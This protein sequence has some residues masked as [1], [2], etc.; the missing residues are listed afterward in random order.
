MYLSKLQILGFK[1]F[2]QK[3]KLEFNHGLSCIIGPNGSGK[4]NIVDAIRWVLGEQRTTAL[5]SDK[6]ENVIFN[7]TKLRKPVG[8]AEVALTIQNNRNILN[9]EFNEVVI[10]RR[11]Y[12]S[13]ESEYLINQTP[14]RLKD[15]LDLFMDT[16]MGA[17][18]YSVIE[19]KMVESILSENKAE[20]R[21]LFE[22]AAGVV[23][24]KIR[25]KSALR[26]LEVT[27]IDLTRINDIIGEVDKKVQ[28]L[29]RQVGKTRRY[30][31]YMEE[32]RKT[33]IALSRFRYHR[34]LD[35]LRPLKQQ[36]QEVSR[37]KE[38]SH[39]Q[40]TMDEALLE[41]YKREQIQT[42]QILQTMN[43]Q[44]H[45]LDN[46][47]AQINQEQAVAKTK[48]EEITKTKDRYGI[49]IDDFTKKIGLIR[50]NLTNYEEDLLRLNGQK[51]IFDQKYSEIE[52]ERVAEIDRLQIEKS[53]ID[54]LNKDFRRRF[55]AVSA[56][57]DHLKQKEYQLGFQQDQFNHLEESIAA[58]NT[59]VTR[60]STT[61]QQ[62]QQER[63]QFGNNI[64]E[65]TETLDELVSNKIK[66]S[67]QQRDLEHK[68][69]GLLIELERAHSRQHF[70]ES[71]I[72]NYEGHS[73][74]TQY[75]MSQRD[76]MPGV[77][78]ALADLVSVDENY[79]R[80]IELV[81]GEALNYVIVDNENI[82]G[83]LIQLIK[84][85]KKGRI[86][87][88][89][90]NR[91]NELNPADPSKETE[92]G[93]TLLL[94]QITCPSSYQKLLHVLMGDVAVCDTLDEALTASKNYPRLRFITA[95]GEI[96]NFGREIS[97]GSFEQDS[98][99][100]V[101]RKDQLKKYNDQARHLQS[102][103]NA[104]TEQIEALQSA[105]NK[106][107]GDETSLRQQISQ[108]QLRQDETEKK[109]NQIAFELNKHQ[110]D[111]QA[112]EERL[113]QSRK[114]IHELKQQT[115]T[116]QVA[117]E[118]L[119]KELN[120]LERETIL[121]TNEYEQKSEVM[122]GLLEEVQK[123][124]LNAANLQ[125]QISNRQQDIQR[126][127]KQTKDLQDDI[128]KR[129]TEIGQI[130]Q[131]LASIA[132][133][134]EKQKD[135]QA[136]I[137]EARDQFDTQREQIEQKVQEIRDKILE[138]E[139]Q[140]RKYRRQH[141]SSL[142]RTRALDIKIAENQFK[143]E[144]VREHIRKEYAEDVEIGLPFDDLNEQESGEKIE[145]IRARI[146]NLG[147]V[148]PLA[149]TEY[150]QEKERFDFLS[151]QRDDL[152]KAE[153]SL[154]ETIDKINKTAS[155]QFTETFNQIKANFELVFQSFFENGE[156]TILLDEA[157]DPLEADIEVQVR[158]KGKR[159][160]TLAL[161][162]G[163]E[164]TLTAISLLFSIYLVKPSPFCILDEVDA[165]LD[166]I[167]IGRFTEALKNFS[168]KTQF[169]VV[170]HNKRTMEAAQ[171]MYGVTMEEE[172][173]SKLVSVKFT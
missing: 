110:K 165:P 73:K 144:N 156:G 113:S 36:L 129:Q 26:N 139:E 18:S 90:L 19:L 65:L 93:F 75:V 66:I 123:A 111:R 97:G 159:L 94:R 25:R 154:M 52:L 137:W 47:L 32:L 9:T 61:L 105:Q 102:E 133:N 108:M 150:D 17:N 158:T 77:H 39:H 12:R 10:S 127:H 29:H 4:S 24:Y 8:L 58:H 76:R 130:E 118:V 141:D 146:K 169:I 70:F 35:E 112:D 99:S 82:A 87:L 2:A 114:I 162:S 126:A 54:Q 48:S 134:A 164:K 85:Q 62:L 34:L 86:T 41:D 131:T 14:V 98:A 168:D 16:G 13:G 31:E 68:R 136:A 166:D 124:R 45:E 140:T 72:A 104:W 132:E 42:E 55:E 96:V 81:L 128:L 69:N 46:R 11:L 106:L 91:I 20:R 172:G 103:L 40:I 23:K 116:L 147:P 161:L 149:V 27:R 153:Q 64:K 80:S 163:G 33:E 148:N 120:E 89:P 92:H 117:I 138:V 56:E 167:N 145:M 101:G 125:N 59:A 121:R 38:E 109:I 50:E 142:E 155:A 57:K 74:S 78:G 107:I 67:E 95:Q 44:I 28:T 21:L 171:T 6:M 71:I 63:D 43:R 173:V 143:A 115:E 152:L 88:I 60:L 160:Q 119:Q 83:E 37:L 30:L 170:T 22:E 49:E 5:R 79:A 7:G 135:E 122:Q 53:E 84:S 100:I 157:A 51:E 15:V 3:T 1:S 151:K